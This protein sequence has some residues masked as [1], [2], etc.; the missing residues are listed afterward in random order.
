MHEPRSSLLRLLGDT[1]DVLQNFDKIRDKK[2]HEFMPG[3]NNFIGNSINSLAKGGSELVDAIGDLIKK[4]LEGSSTVINSIGDAGGEIIKETGHSVSNILMSI[5]GPISFGLCLLIIIFLTV[6]FLPKF[7]RKLRKPKQSHKS[8]QYNADS[9][10]IEEVSLP[11]NAC[12]NINGNMEPL[13]QSITVP[14]RE[15]VS[16][17]ITS[18]TPNSEKQTFSNAISSAEDINGPSHIYQIPNKK[19]DNVHE[20]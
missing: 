3:L 2:T 10:E 11:F 4:D 13:L 19:T 20:D 17:T 9:E 7:K 12:Q 14:E 1:S 5:S 18:I 16:S 8:V 15:S 6:Q